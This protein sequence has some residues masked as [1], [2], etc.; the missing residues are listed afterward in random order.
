MASLDQAVV[1]K[2]GRLVEL[3]RHFHQNAELSFEEV[4]T[5]AFVLEQ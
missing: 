3:R 5:A 4:G 1:A 2:T